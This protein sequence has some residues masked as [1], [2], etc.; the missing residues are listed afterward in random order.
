MTDTNQASEEVRTKLALILGY[1]RQEQHSSEKTRWY[2]LDEYGNPIEV[3]KKVDKVID[4]IDQHTKTMCE[5]AGVD[6]L[7]YVMQND[8]VANPYER[9]SELLSCHPNTLRAWD[10]NGYLVAIRIGTRSDRRYKRE[11]VMKLLEKKK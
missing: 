5:R 2:D 4:L 9:A 11:D 3:T 1:E 10:N 6:E 7:E 8:A